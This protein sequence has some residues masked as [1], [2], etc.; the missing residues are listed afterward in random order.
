MYTLP[1]TLPVSLRSFET[2]RFR[3]AGIL[4]VLAWLDLTESLATLLRRLTGLSH[5]RDHGDLIIPHKTNSVIRWHAY[6]NEVLSFTGSAT[7]VMM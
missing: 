7:Q 6:T 1:Y 4:F 5:H 2:R 3:E